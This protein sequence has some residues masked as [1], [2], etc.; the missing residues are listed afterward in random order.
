VKQG[1]RERN[2]CPYNVCTS[3]LRSHESL[4]VVLIAA[5]LSAL[6]RLEMGTS[7]KR[8]LDSSSSLKC[9]TLSTAFDPPLGRSLVSHPRWNKRRCLSPYLTFLTTP[10]HLH[11]SA[12]KLFPRRHS[13]GRL[14]KFHIGNTASIYKFLLMVINFLSKKL[15]SVI[16]YVSKLLNCRKR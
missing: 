16:S 14:I 12:P 1:I 8:F 2:K 3:A 5:H 6:R 10:L 11:S 15:Q 7:V 9:A 4:H 13:R